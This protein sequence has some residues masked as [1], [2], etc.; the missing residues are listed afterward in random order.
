M[1]RRTHKR[2]YP[3]RKAHK[4]RGSRKRLKR[5][6][7]RVSAALTNLL[8]VPD[9]YTLTDA[10]IIKN[11][12][13]STPS[14]MPCEYFTVSSGDPYS[15]NDPVVLGQIIPNLITTAANQSIKY[16]VEEWKMSNTVTNFCLMDVKVIS[17]L[18]KW[19]HDLPAGV[20]YEPKVLLG[21]GFLD[22]GK[23]TNADDSNT[24]CYDD[25]SDPFMSSTF[26]L[27][28]KIVK[29]KT[30]I[31]APGASKTYHLKKSKPFMVHPN[32]LV[33]LAAG[34]NY[35]PGNSVCIYEYMRGGMFYLYKVSALQATADTS[36]TLRTGLMTSR[37]EV[38]TM[39]KWKWTYKFMNNII[40]TITEASL[41]SS[42]LVDG[43]TMTLNQVVNPTSGNINTLGSAI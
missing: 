26:C 22:N 30:K 35:A 16:S 25:T 1:P 12:T 31:L 34:A 10:V 2:K 17:Y 32:L 29:V 37:F 8:A 5:S 4:R 27:H 42:L 28:C 21:Q 24:F 6:S 9:Y 18:C 23:G 3:K 15:H 40:G 14:H 11:T 38:R 41:P 43:S 39:T 13:T 36:T 20:S 7:N 33:T 19:R